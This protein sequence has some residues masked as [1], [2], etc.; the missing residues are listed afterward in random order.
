MA[1]VGGV[2]A[3]DLDG[4]SF[5]ETAIKAPITYNDKPIGFIEG[6][7]GDNNEMVCVY[8]WTKDIEVR[9]DEDGRVLSVEL[10][11]SDYEY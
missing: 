9:C 6:F 1:I 2:F 10:N 3:N 11:A 7:Q 8:V 4:Y 5:D